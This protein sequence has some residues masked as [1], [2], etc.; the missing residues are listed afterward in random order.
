MPDIVPEPCQRTPHPE[1]NV[2]NKSAGFI[3]FYNRFKLILPKKGEPM[4]FDI[5][6]D[7]GEKKDLAGEMP[8]RVAAMTRQLH[9][10]QTSVEISL[11]GADYE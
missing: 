7:R 9:F 1:I 2:N 10:W 8:D 6:A 5:L 4:L 3:S 11:T